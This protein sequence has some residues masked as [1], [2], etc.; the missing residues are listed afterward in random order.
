MGRFR[1]PASFRRLRWKLTLS[2]TAVTVAVLLTLV[3]V[4]L[5]GQFFFSPASDWLNHYLQLATDRAAEAAPF[6]ETPPLSPTL[7]EAWLQAAVPDDWAA[8][9]GPSGELVATNQQEPD[10]EAP[11]GRPLVDPEAPGES[12]QVIDEALSGKPAVLG[13]DDGSIVAAAPIIGEGQEVVGAQYVRGFEASLLP[14]WNLG[15]GLA[16]L[17]SSLIGL[18]IGAGLIGTLFGRLAS[19]GLVRRLESLDSAAEAWGEG[20]FTTTVQDD[21]PDELGQ[22][23]RRM[24]QM[25]LQ[26]QDLLRMRQELATSEER[27]RLARDL[28]DSVKQQAFATTMTLGTAK[29]LREQAPEAAWEKVAEAEDLSYEVQQEL[30]NLIHELR[31]IELQGKGLAAALQEYSAR[32]S[33]QAGVEARVTLDGEHSV[34]PETEQA[35]FRLAQ[36]ALANVAKHAEAKQVAITL[37]RTDGTITMSVADDGHGFDPESAAG[38]GLGLHSMRERIEALGGALSVESTPGTGTRLVARLELE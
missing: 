10:G 4:G 14:G 32:W 16:I 11:P 2:Y 8:I 36:E 37:V 31:P 18:T 5:F 13:L 38:K 12:R 1:F 33:R 29:T 22:L 30:A 21:S 20:N 25:A 7:M 24:N 9:V 35:L 6:L 34:P 3:A 15:A 27:N 19:R 28:H 17:I 26:V 23:A